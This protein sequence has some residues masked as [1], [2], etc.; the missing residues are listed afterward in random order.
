MLDFD[1]NKSPENST[2]TSSKCRQKK[3]NCQ[4]EILY[5]AN[6]TFKKMWNVYIVR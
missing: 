1:R 4:P 6:I 5:V 2:V 3:K